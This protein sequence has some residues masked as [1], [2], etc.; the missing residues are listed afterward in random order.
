MQHR[1]TRRKF[2]ATL[3][4][5]GTV[6][7]AGCSALSGGSGSSNTNTST[8]TP[9]GTSTKSPETTTNG[10]NSGNGGDGSN[11]SG[12]NNNNNNKKNAPFTRGKVVADFEGKVG[13]EW[14]VDYGKLATTTKDVYRGKQSIVLKPRK[15][16]KRKKSLN[17][18]PYARIT[19]FF[20]NKPLDLS[21][22]DLTM[23]V[24][25]EKPDAIDITAKVYAPTRNVSLQSTRQIKKDMNDWVR[26][27]IG[28]TSKNGKP[29]L[30]KVS[31]VQLIVN[32]PKGGP[33]DFKVKIDDLRMIPK[34]K[35]GKVILQVDDGHISTY[36]NI[37][38]ILKQKGWAAG[39]AVI[40]SVIGADNRLGRKQM[41]E[42]SKNG[43]DIMSH[44]KAPPST[45]LPGLPKKVQRQKIETAKQQLELLGFKK[46]S[47]HLVA[48]YNR[49]SGTTIDILRDVHET[50]FLFGGCPN[51]GR[52][53]SNP[54]FISRVQ[55]DSPRGAKRIIDTAAQFNQMAVVQFHVVG[56]YK[57][58]P[59]A[60]TVNRFKNIMNYIEKQNVDVITPSQLI[61]GKN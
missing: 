1:S 4:A 17:G 41:K 43:W 59:N 7:F 45:G 38:P 28:Y 50:A 46:G 27:D 22:N 54:Y 20:T 24:K 26:Y 21:K 32:I 53:P 6:T 36:E 61:D 19:N 37:Y 33:N 25:V 2:I 15:P 48:P 52:K 9:K 34:A 31:A 44:P 5:A 35:K 51:N 14:Q 8:S 42:M 12:G 39:A 30:S 11:N 55:G 57:N 47:R 3:G 18:R 40:P 60:L 29:D 13:S 10:G 23:A 58:Y 16:S 56:N 49:L